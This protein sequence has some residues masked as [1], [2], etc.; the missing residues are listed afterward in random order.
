MGICSK[1]KRDAY[2]YM[3]KG[4]GYRARSAYK[5]LDIE[6][7]FGIFHHAE[8]IVDLC[9]APGSWSQVLRSKTGAQI[10]AIDVQEM[11]P[12]PGV[13]AIKDDIT[14]S[15]CLEQLNRIFG[16]EKADL[17]ICDGAPEV[18]GFHDLD[19]YLQIDLLKAALGISLVAARPGSA[20]V[21]KCFKGEYL[22]NI[23]RH[24]MKFYKSVDVVKPQS[25]RAASAE[26]FLLC[27]GMA[28]SSHD[29]QRMDASNDLPCVEIKECGQR[30]AER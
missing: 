11:A 5:L 17:V 4:A 15:S 1:D 9:A 29:L 22:G 30:H 8:R 27:R 7:T 14:S 6:H 12:I 10:V 13:V 19:E 18:T 16:N 20:F 28:A 21:G 3:A 24:F 2:Y 25:S 26:C 23:V